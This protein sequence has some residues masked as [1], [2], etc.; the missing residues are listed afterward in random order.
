MYG[1]VRKCGIQ[2]GA[3]IW[4]EKEMTMGRKRKDPEETLTQADVP[5][6]KPVLVTVDKVSIVAK[7]LVLDL[8]TGSSEE[9]APKGYKLPTWCRKAS[10]DSA[11]G[12]KQV[13][14]EFRW[15]DVVMELPAPDDSCGYATYQPLAIYR[16]HAQVRAKFRITAR[17]HPTMSALFDLMMDPSDVTFSA[18]PHTPSLPLEEVVEEEDPDGV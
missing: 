15:R 2:G 17:L 14:V 8:D 11:L 6:T 13:F 5:Q 12:G 1:I 3:K 7:E 4:V 18:R 10:F 16:D 9:V